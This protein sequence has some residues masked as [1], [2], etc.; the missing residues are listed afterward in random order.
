MNG[1]KR[2]VKL[3]RDIRVGS[4]RKVEK[5]LKNGRTG[6]Y[7]HWQVRL[8]GSR[9]SG[10][11]KGFQKVC[12]DMRKA[13]TDLESGKSGDSIKETEAFRRMP[14]ELYCR[15]VLD[16]ASDLRKT[17]RQNYRSALSYWVYNLFGHR[18]LGDIGK[19]D[20]ERLSVAMR[21]GWGHDKQRKEPVG[22]W[23]QRNVR[24]ALNF[25]LKQAYDDGFID[26]NWAARSTFKIVPKPIP[27]G[28]RFVTVGDKN[29]LL[30]ALKGANHWLYGPMLVG[31]DYGM[32]PAEVAGLTWDRFFD[33]DGDSPA[34]FID[35]QIKR[36]TGEGLVEQP[37]KTARGN[38]AE[39]ITGELLAFVKDL[40]RHSIY[41]FVNSRRHPIDVTTLNHELRK[42]VLK[43]KL[44]CFDGSLPAFT[45]FCRRSWATERKKANIP[46]EIAAK[47]AGHST[48]MADEVYPQ[49]YREAQEILKSKRE[50]LETIAAK[51]RATTPAGDQAIAS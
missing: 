35:K 37:P 8:H 48:A 2:D 38:R 29:K 34:F 33:L 24:D 43:L 14:L 47:I 36:I 28:G 17:T 7:F 42:W 31:I 49:E 23:T 39:P 51:R 16:N 32:R 18:L 30:N 11:T 27:T 46:V 44:H 41:V 6:T 1:N 25:C 9:R 40:A 13:I 4:C 10:E 21:D 5:T 45:D 50:V 20:I 12:T 22:Y 26:R 3:P 19:S 15:A